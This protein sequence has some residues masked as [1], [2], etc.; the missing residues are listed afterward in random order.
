MLNAA[1]VECCRSL[2][3]LFG[4]L[5]SSNAPLE[6]KMKAL[7]F[8]FWAAPLHTMKGCPVADA[9]ISFLHAKAVGPE[10]CICG[11]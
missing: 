4:R 1:V 11:Q 10:A 8:K 6:A 2:L 3:P 9:H 5:R 7:P